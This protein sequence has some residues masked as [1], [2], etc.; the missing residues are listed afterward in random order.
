MVWD[1]AR[2][3]SI[4]SEIIKKLLVCGATGFIGRNIT[5][6][7]SQNREFEVYATYHDRPPFECDNVRWV[8]ADLREKNDVKEVLQGVNVLIQAAAT[9]SG[10]KD[11]VNTPYIHVTDNAVMN[12]LIFREAYE[13]NIEHVVFFSCTVMYQSSENPVREE[14][15]NANEE[16]YPNYFAAAWTKLYIEKQA[17]FYS[18]LGKNKYTILRHSNVYGPHDKYDLERS[19]VFGA[20]VTKVMTNQDGKMIVWGSGEAARDLIHVDDITRFVDMSIHKQETPYG[21]YNVGSGYAI[22]IRDIVQ[23]IIAAS[24]KDITIEFDRSK[25]DIKTKLCVDCTR[26]YNEIG[27]KP[28]INIDDG[29]VST[30]KWYE[31][32]ILE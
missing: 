3:I 23:K 8:K 22:A 14:D 26:A 20:T 4:W 2:C 16:I 17:E 28:E 27:W 1:Q 29:I 11:I 7:Y 6:F 25:P 13:A 15:F 19:H 30:L 31:N 21:L 32:N 24:G 9:T 18:R 5:E 10:S 12:S